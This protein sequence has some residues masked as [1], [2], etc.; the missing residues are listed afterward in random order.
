MNTAI[1]IAQGITAAMFLLAGL[2]KILQPKEKLSGKMS[3]VND[4]STPMVKLVGLAEV[5]GGI[6]LIVPQ[7]TGILPVLTPVAAVALVLV[8][9]LAA[10]YHFRKNEMKAIGTNI[11]LTLLL[12]FVAWGRFYGTNP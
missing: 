5:L 12:A 4:Y 8:M 9:V 7:A 2:M 1:W 6:G 10:G 11:V 3:W